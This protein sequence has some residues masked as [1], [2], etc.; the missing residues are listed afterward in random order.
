VGRGRADGL[1]EQP[2]FSLDF[3]LVRHRLEVDLLDGRS[4]EFTWSGGRWPGS[5]SG[6]S[7][8][9]WILSQVA[10]L[11]DRFAADFAGKTSPV[12]HFWHTFDIGPGG[13]TDPC[14]AKA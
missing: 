5:T 3:D 14:Y 13:V 7:T 8:R 11:L 9:W 4:A 2:L 12:H 6:C 10:Q 1:G